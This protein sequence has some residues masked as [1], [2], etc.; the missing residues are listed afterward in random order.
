MNLR[1]KESYSILIVQLKFYS[2]QNLL[3]NTFQIKIKFLTYNLISE[4]LLYFLPET[5]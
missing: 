5:I 1:K 2:L 3:D 4:Y